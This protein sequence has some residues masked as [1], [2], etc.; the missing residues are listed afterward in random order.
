MSIL[1]GVLR[2]SHMAARDAML[3]IHSVCMIASDV[4]L[5]KKYGGG[6]SCGVV[7]G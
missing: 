1:T 2:L 4:Q 3:D 7:M 6:T 5:N